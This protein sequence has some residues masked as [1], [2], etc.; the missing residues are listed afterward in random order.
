MDCLRSFS[1]STNRIAT[2]TT[3]SGDLKQWTT[4]VG[5]NYWQAYAGI[6]N[7]VYNIQGFK[8][9]EVYGIDVLGTIQTQANIGIDGNI[10][11]DWT[12]D[13]SVNGQQPLVGGTVVAGYY[14]IDTTLPDNNIFALGNT[15]I[16]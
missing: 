16:V 8:N 14:N 2:I 6:P 3:A 11:S 7:S 5:D 15:Q 12:I 4:G 13:V 1:F 10:V 9:I